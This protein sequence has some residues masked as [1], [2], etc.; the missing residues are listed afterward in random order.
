M[1]LPWV[2]SGSLWVTHGSPMGLYWQSIDHP[3][4]TRVGIQWPSMDHPWVTYGSYMG[5]PWGFGGAS[6]V[7]HVS[8][9]GFPFVYI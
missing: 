9:T 3:W 4:V 7:T 2:C 5:L 1:S 8:P 6:W